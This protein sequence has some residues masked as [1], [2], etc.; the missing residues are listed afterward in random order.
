MIDVS[1]REHGPVFDGR[2]IHDITLFLQAATQAVAIEGEHDVHG[3]LQGSLRH[4]TGYY[5]SRVQVDPRGQSDH[6]I[7]D[8]GVIYGPWLE[9][10]GSRNATTR[11]KGYHTFR[12]VT[13]EL[14]RKARGIA[15]RV[16][17]SYVRMMNG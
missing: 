13:Q 3:R 10:T 4:P 8:S 2:A 1:V 6:V 15:F 17:D 7:S 5:E 16:L 11:F 12:K 9:G 14:D